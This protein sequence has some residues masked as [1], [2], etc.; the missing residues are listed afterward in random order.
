MATDFENFTSLEELYVLSSENIIQI[1]DIIYI[2][3]QRFQQ[4]QS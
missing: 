2:F 3:I 1:G 4:Q